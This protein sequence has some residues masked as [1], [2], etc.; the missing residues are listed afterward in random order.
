M[1]GKG[2]HRWLTVITRPL[3]SVKTVRIWKMQA[4]FFRLVSISTFLTGEEELEQLIGLKP[5]K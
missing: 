4:L 1:S 3:M 5:V 2:Y